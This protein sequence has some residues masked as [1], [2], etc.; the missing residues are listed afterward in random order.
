M[1]STNARLIYTNTI[2]YRSYI[3]GL[4]L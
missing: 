1:T 2:L 4:E 3:R